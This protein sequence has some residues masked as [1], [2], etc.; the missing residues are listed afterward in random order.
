ME[1]R[2]GAL[3]DLDRVLGPDPFKFEIPIDWLVAVVEHVM[4]GR[5]EL[6]IPELAGVRL[7]VQQTRDI[8]VVQRP[9]SIPGSTVNRSARM[10]TSTRL[11]TDPPHARKVLPVC[12]VDERLSS[13]GK[14]TDLVWRTDDGI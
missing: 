8:V 11:R 3:R 5:V 14:G 2:V 10:S 6:V 4:V 12:F 1:R 7:L 13:R 9:R